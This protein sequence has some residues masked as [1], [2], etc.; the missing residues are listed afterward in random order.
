[1]VIM[2]PHFNPFLAC[3][4]LIPPPH[5]LWFNKSINNDIINFMV[6]NIYSDQYMNFIIPHDLLNKELSKLE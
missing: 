1:M 2:T 5:F 3:N 4:K 6:E